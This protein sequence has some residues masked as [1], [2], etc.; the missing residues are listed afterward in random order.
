MGLYLGNSEKLKISLDG[1]VS[2]LNIHSATPI[3]NGVRLLTLEDYILKDS[4]GL[5]LTVKEDE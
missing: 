4:N 2:Y 1:V 5:Y 3:T